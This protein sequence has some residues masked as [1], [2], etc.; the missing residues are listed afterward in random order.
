MCLYTMVKVQLVPTAFIQG[1]FEYQVSARL[2]K[3]NLI[4]SELSSLYLIVVRTAV[5]EKDLPRCPHE[6][7]GEK[8]YII[9]SFE[10]LVQASHTHAGCGIFQ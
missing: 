3:V 9:I 2:Q 6:R 8:S 1:T 7:V 4:D 5:R 10:I